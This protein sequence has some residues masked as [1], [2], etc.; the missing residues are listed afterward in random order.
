MLDVRSTNNY[1]WEDVLATACFLLNNRK[2]YG[3]SAAKVH[4]KIQFHV[5]SN[6]ETPPSSF[7]TM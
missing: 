2:F 1:K 7:P 4:I 6:I 5:I 3:E